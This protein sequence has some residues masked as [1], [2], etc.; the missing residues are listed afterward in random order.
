MHEDMDA[1]PCALVCGGRYALFPIAISKL[2]PC[3]TLQFRAIVR[4]R[5]LAVVFWFGG[6]GALFAAFGHH[7]TSLAHLVAWMLSALLTASVMARFAE[8]LPLTAVL[9]PAAAGD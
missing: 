9:I 4:R 8:V 2:F 5:R 6:F 3:G 7:G 1:L